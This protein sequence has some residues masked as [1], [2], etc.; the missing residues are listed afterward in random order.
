MELVSK[1]IAKVMGYDFGAIVVVVIVFNTILYLFQSFV[2]G[3]KTVLEKYQDQTKTDL[4]NKAAAL[5]GVLSGYIASALG[6]FAKI[7]DIVGANKEH[8]KK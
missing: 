3:V 8:N 1:I 7:A 4:D 5:L 2:V 6:V